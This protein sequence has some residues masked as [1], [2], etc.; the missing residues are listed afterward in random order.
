MKR[1]R[2]AKITCV[3]A[4]SLGPSV[5]SA[6][7]D[8]GVP[9][10]FVQNGKQVCLAERGGL[11]GFLPRVDLEDSASLVYRFYVPRER[12]EDVGARIVDAAD[13][14]LPGRGSLF[15]EPAELLS[16]DDIRQV[17]E[18]EEERRGRIKEAIKDILKPRQRLQDYT[19]LTCIVQR[20]QGEPLART[21]LEMGL[22]VP[23]VTYGRG[24]GL[25]NKLGLLR[26]TIPVEKE[27]LYFLVPTAD[28][29]LV[30]SIAVHKARLDRPGQGFIYSNRVRAAAVNARVSRTRRR[31]VAT[32][33][34]VIT[35]VDSLQGSTDWRRLSAASAKS[36]LASGHPGPEQACL[37]VS[38]DEGRASEFVRAAMD[39]GAGGATLMRVRYR[40]LPGP[41]G[42]ERRS[43]DTSKTSHARESCDLIIP[44]SL[45]DTVLAAMETRGL[46]ESGVFGLV[47]ISSVGKAVT[48]RG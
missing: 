31:H 33:E 17:G 5:L 41:E 32:M 8:A 15:V 7:G 27:V 39:V 2:V 29:A 42:T 19:A 35:A 23:V 1:E 28:A 21:I 9:D 3:A 37:S 16:G 46:F 38:C 14:S 36:R 25:R 45:T 47:E 44:E 11:F 43:P 26:I 18:G 10:V 13:L 4:S 22:C 20:G 48:Y 34:Q 24:M 40:D 12:A 6:L 30:E